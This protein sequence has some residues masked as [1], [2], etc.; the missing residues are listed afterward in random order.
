MSNTSASVTEAGRRSE[1]LVEI[2]LAIPPQQRGA[3][4][5]AALAGHCVGADVSAYVTSIRKGFDEYW[6]VLRTCNAP[7]GA[8][9]KFLRRPC[10]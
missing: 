10:R 5:R 6:A 7:L 9:A 4:L 2:L 1:S 8:I 3:A